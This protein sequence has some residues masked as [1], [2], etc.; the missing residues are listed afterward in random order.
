MSKIT[1]QSIV[2][3]LADHYVEISL[4]LAFAVGRDIMYQVDGALTESYNT[5][6]ED[7]KKRVD[8]IAQDKSYN[9]GFLE[10]K[11]EGIRQANAENKHEILRLRTIEQKMIEFIEPMALDIVRRVGSKRKIQCIRE[12]REL[13]GLGLRDSKDLVEKVSKIIDEEDAYIEKMSREGFTE[14]E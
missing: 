10:G 3:A 4:S 11:D 5:G 13:S 2:T 6:F 9:R 1:V 14:T 7:G 12:V 8:Y